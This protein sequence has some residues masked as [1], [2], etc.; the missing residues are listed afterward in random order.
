VALKAGQTL[1]ADRRYAI[2]NGP[3]G[4]DPFVHTIRSQL[5]VG[6]TAQRAFAQPADTNPSRSYPT[7]PSTCSRKGRRRKQPFGQFGIT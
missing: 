4:F 7:M 3:S 2:E 5:K 1:S 6:G